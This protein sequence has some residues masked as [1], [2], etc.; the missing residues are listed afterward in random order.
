MKLRIHQNSL[1]FRFNRDEVEALSRGESLAAAVQIGPGPTQR[2]AYCVAPV[3]E[4][5]GGATLRA[6]MEGLALDVSV[7]ADAIRRW[8]ESPELALSAEQDSGGSTL[9]VLL[10]KD[11][12]RLNPKPEEEAPNVYPNP[13]FGKARCDHP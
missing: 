3:V 5:L 12:Q 2:F 11:M 7:S 6:R 13:L 9:K 10:E 8:H 1:R 4:G